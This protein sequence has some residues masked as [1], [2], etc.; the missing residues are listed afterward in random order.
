M[1]TGGSKIVRLQF[2]GGGY[3][4]NAAGQADASADVAQ[5]EVLI[6]L[7]AVARRRRPCRLGGAPAPQ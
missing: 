2:T 3:P 1:K 7:K 4:P 5:A 6:N